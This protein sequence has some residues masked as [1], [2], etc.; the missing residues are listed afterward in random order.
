MKWNWN[1]A[2]TFA[3]LWFSIGLGFGAAVEQQFELL[4]KAL[5]KGNINNP[6]GWL[7]MAL[8]EGYVD[9][10]DE[11]KKIQ[12][13]KKTARREAA[14]EIER[15]QLAVLQREQEEEASQFEIREDS[16]F[17][18]FLA[19]LKKEHDENRRM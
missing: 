16:P 5:Q 10:A 17:Y 14:A 18:G 6:A 4:K 7:H 13:E 1:K 8:Q 9:T 3:F 12:D 15:Q 2:I 19:K 11:F